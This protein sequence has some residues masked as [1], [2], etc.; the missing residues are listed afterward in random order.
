[1]AAGLSHRGSKALLWLSLSA[2]GSGLG[3]VLRGE[4][5]VGLTRAFLFAGSRSVVVSLWN[6]PDRAT[7]DF[8]TLFY[9]ALRGGATPPAALRH[10]LD[11]RMG[12]TD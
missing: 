9:E 10:A 4:G 12:S 1:M 2:C 6:L 8:M 7:S 3:Q 11:G 5:L